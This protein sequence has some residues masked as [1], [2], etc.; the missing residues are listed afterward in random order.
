[1]EIAKEMFPDVLFHWEDFGRANVSVILEKYKDEVTTFND[2]IQGTG[3]MMAAAMNAVA[4]V[5]EL[6][7]TEQ[8]YVVFGGGTVGIG[9]S[10]QIRNEMMR[11][12]MSEADAM[13]RFYIVDRFGLVTADQEN[14]TEGQ[15]RYARSADEFATP[16][17]TL[18]EVVAAIKPTVLIGTSGQANTFTQEIVEIMSENTARPAIMP[19][20]NPTELQEGSA[21]DII[22]WSKGKALV[23]TGSPSDPVEYDGVTYLIGQANNSLLYPG[24]GAGIVV[25]KASTVTD[26]MLSAAAHGIVDIQDLSEL[27]ASLLPPVETAKQA[28][29]Y[30]AMAVVKAAIED[31]VNKNQISDVEAAVDASIWDAKY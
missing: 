9:V 6:P 15:T 13:K 22:A 10:D 30:V 11:Q 19:I 17:A 24:L 21:S 5:S 2:D 18:T 4:K 28:S 23:V 31:K 1:M 20:S 3:V 14:L 8:T 26:G 7:V 29:K 12:G 25:A 16:L 27:G